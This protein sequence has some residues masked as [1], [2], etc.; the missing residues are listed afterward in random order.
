MRSLLELQSFGLIRLPNGTYVLCSDNDQR[1]IRTVTSPVVIRHARAEDRRGNISIYFQPVHLNK[2][3]G[4][5]T[6]QHDNN[7]EFLGRLLNVPQD[8]WTPAEEEQQPTATDGSTS[9]QQT[10]AQ[11]S[12][13]A[14][15]TPQQQPQTSGTATAMPQQ[16]P[17]TSRTAQT[18]PQQQP[19]TSRTA[20]YTTQSRIHR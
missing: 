15:A 1:R 19:Q 8:M 9:T 3:G 7:A 16:Q 11:T 5:Y 18:T 10:Q 2:I 6:A 13:T 4:G 12:G 20:R 17:Q 14:P